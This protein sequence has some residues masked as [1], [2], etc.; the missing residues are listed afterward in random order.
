MHRT[1]GL[2][3]HSQEANELE[4]HKEVGLHGYIQWL[5]ISFYFVGHT[6]LIV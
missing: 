2:S 3:Q 4:E 6:S 5:D 1:D